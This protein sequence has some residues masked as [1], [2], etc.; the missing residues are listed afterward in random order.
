MRAR[1][2]L[3]AGRLLRVPGAHRP[4]PAL[5]TYPGLT[6]R[7]WHE[8]DATWVRPWIDA[9]EAATPAITREYEAIKKLELPSDY[10]G[11]ASDHGGHLHT[12]AS[13]WHW[14]SLIDRGVARPQ[15]QQHCPQ[16]MAALNAVPG[17]CFGDMPFAFAFFSALRPQSRIAPHTAPANLRLRVHLPLVV[18]EPDRC[19]IRVANEARRWEVGKALIFDDS[20]EHETWNEGEQERVVLLFDLWHPDLQRDEIDAIQAMFREV[21]RMKETRQGQEP[22]VPSSQS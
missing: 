13:E 3:V 12:G 21:K 19:G 9:L 7:P 6:S 4:A 15:M 14:S 5:L 20:F 18:P 1:A 11:D 8:R 16:T 10:E 17:L 22:S 2:T